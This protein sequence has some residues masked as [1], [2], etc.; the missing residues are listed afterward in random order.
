MGDPPGGVDA[1]LAQFQRL[2]AADKRRGAAQRVGAQT[3]VIVRADGVTVRRRGA[4][5]IVV[6]TIQEAV[7]Q[8]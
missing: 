3:T 4:E 2:A 6:E 8:L 1:D 7:E 5:D